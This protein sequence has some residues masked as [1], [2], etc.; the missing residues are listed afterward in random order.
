MTVSCHTLRHTHECVMAYF[1]NQS[2]SFIYVQTVMWHDTFIYV[3]NYVT[4]TYELVTHI[5]TSHFAR[6][7]MSWR[8]CVCLHTCKITCSHV[9]N[10]S[11]ICATWCIQIVTWFMI[12]FQN[13]TW[14]IIICVT[15]HIPL[16]D[17]CMTHSHHFLECCI[18]MNVSCHTLWH[19]YKWVLS[20]LCMSH[21]CDMTRTY[22]WCSHRL[23]TWMCHVTPCGTHMNESCHTCVWVIC[24]KWPVH[25]CDVH[26]A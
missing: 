25:M 22:V 9:W 6:V 2:F 4:H 21:M 19:T 18:H 26:I 23:G 17:M 16:N 11:F 7:N 1:A 15:W 24:V 13:V 5:R 20:H 3:Q 10:D 8:K 12:I 14:F